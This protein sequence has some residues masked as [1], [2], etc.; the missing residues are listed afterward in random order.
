MGKHQ[1]YVKNLTITV[2]NITYRDSGAMNFEKK[3]LNLVALY[4]WQKKKKERRK[5]RE[6]QQKEIFFGH[7]YSLEG[8]IRVHTML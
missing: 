5:E 2:K 7:I 8:E 1:T 6:H 4:F 3:K